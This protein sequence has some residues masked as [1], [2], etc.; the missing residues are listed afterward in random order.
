MTHPSLRLMWPG[1]NLSP[2][3]ASLSPIRDFDKMTAD[4]KE[5]LMVGALS[6]VRC[7]SLVTCKPRG[8]DYA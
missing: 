7:K 5:L 6:R 3:A 8:Y 1:G 4:C 2:A